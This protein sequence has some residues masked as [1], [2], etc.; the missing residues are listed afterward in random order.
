MAVN[1]C[2]MSADL[3]QEN[4]YVHFRLCMDSEV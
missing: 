3:W 1:V 2:D 4:A